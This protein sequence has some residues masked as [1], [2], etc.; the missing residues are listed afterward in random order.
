MKKFFISILLSA[1]FIA[2]TFAANATV[3]YA[4]GKVEVQNG[5]TW[6]PLKENDTIPKG[7]VI[8][9][10]FKSQAVIKFQESTFTLEPL[11]RITVEQLAVT[12]K[13]DESKLYVS[14]GKVKFD[15]KTSQDKRA[16][17]QARSPIA[18]ASVRGTEGTFGAD[19]SLTTIRGM[20]SHGKSTD[21]EPQV[22]DDVTEE[23]AASEENSTNGKANIFTSVRS[24]GGSVG[25]T[26]V[27][28][29]QTTFI[30]PS[31]GFSTSPQ[32]TITESSGLTSG[33]TSL[34]A[35]ESVSTSTVTVP[36]V[37]QAPQG[38]RVSKVTIHT[39]WE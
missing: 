2:G 9:T 18:T 24:V 34:A 5:S 39:V 11:T 15:I 35:A 26:P 20:V 27:F 25:N 33:T 32:V 31:T 10:G 21:K 12:S 3:I 22:E 14:S 38:P 30:N 17:F 29:G 36:V 6:V 7:A 16:S 19:G 28:E 8:S 13:T 1:A 4:E 37:P 23:N